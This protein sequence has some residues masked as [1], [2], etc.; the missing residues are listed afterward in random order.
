MPQDDLVILPCDFFPPQAL[1]LSAV[2]NQYRTATDGMIMH[3][4]WYELFPKEKESVDDLPGPS[5]PPLIVFDEKT[6]SLLHIDY[7]V[8]DQEDITL[9]MGLAWKC[10]QPLSPKML[11]DESY[12]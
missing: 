11:S 4:V 8:P 1:S 10:V 3:S 2:L 12:L 9:R 7:S 5:S 6:D